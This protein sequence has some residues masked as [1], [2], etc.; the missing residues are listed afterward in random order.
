MTAGEQLRAEKKA[1][2][3]VQLL[4]GLVGYGTAL[5]FLVGSSL[6]ASSWSVLAEGLSLRTGMSFGWATNLTAVVVLLCWIPLRELP[7]LGTFLNVVLVGTSADLAALFVPPP[8]SLVQQ[9]GYLLLG[10]LM[11]TFS[12]AVYLGARFG[13]GP[14]DGL[15]T[16]AVR[17]SGGKPIWLVRTAIE[18][19]VLTAGW[20]LGGTVGLGTLLIALLMGPLV[21]QFLRVTT[22]RLAADG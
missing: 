4:V 3:L 12:D 20:L 5:T 13:S 6:G 22:V 21:Q 18:L 17:L 14:R 10:L 15:M 1:W 9:I 19:V 16:G 7:G 11:L 8:T 2:R